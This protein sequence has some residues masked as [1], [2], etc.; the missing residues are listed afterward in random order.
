MH[1]TRDASGMKLVL[2][3]IADLALLASFLALLLKD[4][5]PA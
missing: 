3:S 1:S 2:W 5:I 4:Q